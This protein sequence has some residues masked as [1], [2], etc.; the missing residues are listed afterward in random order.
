M[1]LLGEGSPLDPRLATLR[2]PD[3]LDCTLSIPLAASEMPW[4]LGPVE[5]RAG[6]LDLC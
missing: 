3:L 2:R 1:V 6:F 5:P 4:V